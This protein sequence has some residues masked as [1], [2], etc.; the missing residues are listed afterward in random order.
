MSYQLNRVHLLICIFAGLVLAGGFVWLIFFGDAF[1]LFTMAMWVSAGIVL[2]YV[3]G[4][5]ARSILIQKVFVPEEEYDFANDEEY[6]AFMAKLNGETVEPPTNVM[7][8][9]PMQVDAMEFDDSL[10]DPFMEPVDSVEPMSV[11]TT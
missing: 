3:I 5:F 1:P 8:D 2:F 11:E 6:I 9:D 10:D 7:F 4:Q